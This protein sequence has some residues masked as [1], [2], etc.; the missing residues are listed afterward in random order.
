M[1]GYSHLGISKLNEVDQVSKTT[2]QCFLASLLTCKGAFPILASGG[3]VL[4]LSAPV[5]YVG[6][7]DSIFN[8]VPISHWS[9]CMKRDEPFPLSLPSDILSQQ[10][11]GIK[12]C[13]LVPRSGTPAGA[14]LT[15]SS[16]SVQKQYRRRMWKSWAPL[17][18]EVLELN[19][20]FW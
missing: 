4:T 12:C 7:W 14:H 19:T 3:I 20:L 16:V 6:Q 15:L 8:Y 1:T 11:E 17:A 5:T 2:A 9:W 13:K 10:K 18:R